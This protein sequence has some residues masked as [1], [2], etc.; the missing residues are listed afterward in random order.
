LISYGAIPVKEVFDRKSRMKKE[1][2]NQEKQESIISNSR[3][4]VVLV[5]FVENGQK[6]PLT[7]SE[8]AEFKKHHPEIFNILNDPV[9]LEQIDKESPDIVKVPDSWE[10]LAKKIINQLWKHK[11]AEL[12]WK[13]VDPIDLGIPDYFDI[14]KNPMDFS[15]IKVIY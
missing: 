12:F 8:L 14:I 1:E 9:A 15:T 7:I 11:D 6:R 13:P 10:K 3:H 4:K 2:L 5:K